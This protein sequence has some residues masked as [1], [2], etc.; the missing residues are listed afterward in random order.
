MLEGWHNPTL[1]HVEGQWRI[2][3]DSGNVFVPLEKAIPELV[4][5]CLGAVEGLEIENNK[6]F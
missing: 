4:A 6:P 5:A 1:R 3:S 2:Y